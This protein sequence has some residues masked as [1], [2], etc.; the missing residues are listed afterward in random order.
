MAGKPDTMVVC[1][2][3][4]SGPDDEVVLDG[5]VVRASHPAVARSPQFFVPQGLTTAEVNAAKHSLR[6]SLIERATARR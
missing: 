3:S 6:M 5:D 4:H 1:I 2:E